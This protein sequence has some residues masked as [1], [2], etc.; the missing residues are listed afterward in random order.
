MAAAAA[1]C[2]GRCNRGPAAAAATEEERRRKRRKKKERRKSGGRARAP[3]AGG[4]RGA[5]LP[6]LAYT[7]TR[8]I[9]ACPRR[10]ASH[11]PGPCGGK[12]RAPARGGRKPGPLSR[13]QAVSGQ[14]G[15]SWRRAAR[16]RRRE[17]GAWGC[18]DSGAGGVRS[19]R[20]PAGAQPGPRVLLV[21]RTKSMLLVPARKT[22]RRKK[23]T[24]GKERKGKERRG[25]S[26]FFFFHPFL[27]L[28]LLL[29]LFNS[30]LLLV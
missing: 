16:R 20:M 24:K 25:N 29:F 17:G 26:R 1:G 12:D 27:S 10:P 6:A 14:L 21:I 22:Q 3:G 18:G 28:L 23:E 15:G 8:A 11:A 30:G 2:A 7:S 4:G 9:S 19:C 5:T 13:S